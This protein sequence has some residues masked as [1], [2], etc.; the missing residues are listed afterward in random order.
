[1]TRI[2]FDISREGV[3]ALER[4]AIFAGTDKQRPLLNVVALQLRDDALRIASIDSYILSVQTVGATAKFDE[5]TTEILLSLADV[6]EIVRHAKAQLRSGGEFVFTTDG[7]QWET[8]IGAAGISGRCVNGD[9]PNIDQLL[10]TEH[11]EAGTELPIMLRSECLAQLAKLKAPVKF[12]FH[13]QLKPVEWSAH[14][15]AIAGIMMP[16]RFS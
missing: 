13:G 14:S 5:G 11:E 8:A 9:F 3:D 16:V 15:D 10:A 7:D 2:T 1:M 4:A 6:K 12:T